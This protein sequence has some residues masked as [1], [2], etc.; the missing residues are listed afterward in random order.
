MHTTCGAGFGGFLTDTAL[1]KATSLTGIPESC[2]WQFWKFRGRWDTSDASHALQTR[3]SPNN[4]SENEHWV[5]AIFYTKLRKRS[6][7]T[8]WWSF[9][10]DWSRGSSRTD[11]RSLSLKF[12]CAVYFSFS[13]HQTSWTGYFSVVGI[14]RP[15]FSFIFTLAPT[16]QM[17]IE[18]AHAENKNIAVMPI[19]VQKNGWNLTS[20]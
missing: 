18:K 17:E 13:V 20:L 1:Q 9:H 5:I 8:R 4:M 3:L 7:Q 10:P 12:W 2:S 16:R 15:P 11:F 19:Y 14:W 6:L